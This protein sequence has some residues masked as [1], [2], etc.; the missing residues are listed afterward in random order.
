MI[1]AHESNRDDRLYDDPYAPAFVAAARDT[2]L[3]PDAPADVST[4][5]AQ[6][7]RLVDQ[8]SGPHAPKWTNLNGGT[9][10]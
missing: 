4:Q 9:A 7:E 3:H 8:F 1:R 2:F 5:W 6:V 10:S